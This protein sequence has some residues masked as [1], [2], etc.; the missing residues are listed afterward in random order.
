M[1]KFGGIKNLKAALAAI[2]EPRALSTL[3]R[4]SHPVGRGGCDG[5]IPTGSIKAVCKAAFAA[6]VY[7]TSEEL[8]LGKEMGTELSEKAKKDIDP[9]S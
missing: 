4:W 2:G 7:L 8:V 9:C 1:L 3:Y 6:G 5:A